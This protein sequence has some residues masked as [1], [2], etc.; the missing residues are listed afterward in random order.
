MR[1]LNLYA[2][3]GGNRKLWDEKH[4]VVAVENDPA[5]A[6]IYKQHFPNDT[7]IVGDAHEYLRQHFKEFDFIWSSPPCQTHSDIRQ[8]IGVRFK[9]FEPLYPDM[10]LYE[11]IIFLMSNAKCKWVVENVRPYYE[12]L[13]KGQLVQRHLFWSNFEISGIKIEPDGIHKASIADLQKKHGY[14][15][16]KYKLPNKRKALRNCVHPKLGKHILNCATGNATPMLPGVE[17]PRP[18]KMPSS[19]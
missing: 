4:E 10:K 8:N 14:D 15:L 9:G 17:P 11:E 16:S 12:P 2:G 3:I 6:E 1:I 19:L 5:I 18:T 7:V 13:I